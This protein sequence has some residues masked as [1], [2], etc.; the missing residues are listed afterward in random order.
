MSKIRMHYTA[1]EKDD[2]FTPN[3]QPIR[4]YPTLNRWGNFRAVRDTFKFTFCTSREEGNKQSVT[5]GIRRDV[6]KRSSWEI[7]PTSPNHL[8]YPLCCDNARL[9]CH[10]LFLLDLC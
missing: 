6:Q 5:Y 1:A 10:R 9:D 7:S 3:L 4:G 2:L 8:N